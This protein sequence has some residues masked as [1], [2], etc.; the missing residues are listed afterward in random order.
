MAAAYGRRGGFDNH[1]TTKIMKGGVEMPDYALR[2]YSESD[3]EEISQL[4]CDT[5]RS[6]NAKDYSERQ[7]DAWAACGADLSAWNQRLL[8]L[9]TVVAVADGG[10]VGFGGI[11]ENGYLDYLYVHK[12]C[13]RMGVATAILSAL[14]F[15]CKAKEIT[16][17]ASITAKPFFE[18]RGYKVLR[19]NVAVRQ[20]V[21]LVNYY[22]AK[23][24]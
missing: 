22:M 20:G 15:H 4:F 21:G 12:N 23:S 9:Y 19:E 1:V 7:L 14:E 13:Q 3:C 16:T 6:V 8:K 11:D 24:R 17:Y 10:I 18:R 5:I 2:R